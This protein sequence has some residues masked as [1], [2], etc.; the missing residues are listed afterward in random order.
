MFK[1]INLAVLALLGSASAFDLGR[2][3]IALNVLDDAVLD[4][5]KANG[6]QTNYKY[7]NKLNSLNQINEEMF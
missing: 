5:D 2:A 6:Y 4:L 7:E 1:K 3:N